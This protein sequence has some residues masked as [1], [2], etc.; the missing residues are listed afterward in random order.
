MTRAAAVVIGRNEGP[1]LLRCLQSV[2]GR[3]DPVVYVDSASTDGSVDVARQLGVEVVALDMSIRFSF[4]RARNAGAARVLE[5]APDV[6]LVQFVD[7][8]SEIV[9]SWLAQA[10]AVFDAAANVAAVHG[11][12]RERHPRGVLYDHLFELEF[13]PCTEADE[14]FGGMTLLRVAAYTASGRYREGM[15]TFEDHEL[16]FRLRRAGWQIRRLD[17]DMAIHEAGMAHWR[18]WWTRERRAGYGRAELLRVHGWMGDPGWRRAYASIWF[19]AALLP[20]TG[21]VTAPR[22]PAVAMLVCAGY[23]AFLYRIARRM[24]RRGFGTTDAALYAA[25]RVIG[26]FPQL[27]GVLAFL[28]HPPPAP[29]WGGLEGGAPPAPAWGAVRVTYLINQYPKIT[30]TFVRTEIAAVEG[31]GV[32]VDRVAIRRAEA[33][34]L[35]VADQREAPRTRVILDAGIGGLAAALVR[36]T[37]QRPRQFAGALR[38]ALR[39]ERRSERGMAI[40]LAYLAEACVL[41]RWTQERRTEHLHATFGANNAAVALLCRLLGGPPYSFTAHGPEEFAYAEVLSIAEKVAHAAFV[42]VVSEAGRAHLQQCC[43]PAV[44]ERIHLVRCG[45][46][47]RFNAVEP[48]PVPAARRIVWVGRLNAEKAPLLLV[49]AVARLSAAGEGC[50]LVMIGDGPLRAV[51][52]ARVRSLALSDRITLIGWASSDDVRRHI[53]CARALVLPSVAEGLPIVLMEAL[54]LRRPVICTMVGGVAELVESGACGWLVPPGSIDHLASA[55]G[56][57]LNAAPAELEEMGRNGAARVARQ[58]DPTIAAG[59]LAKLFAASASAARQH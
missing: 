46:D 20:V 36:T 29:G 55:I 9:A 44:W 37:L 6:A 25:G 3:F 45:V 14:V 40:H 15:L 26:K 7:A 58:H 49:E 54:A 2:V 21:V 22:W 5:L 48:T 23:V 13:N 34:L 31:A 59:T 33:A 38:M 4:G 43:P 52:E 19:W 30:H 18:A 35:D 1:R 39:M 53:L 57:V 50:D 16:S 47:A 42:A 11:R 17:A 41:L 32:H 51:V 24:R 8:D 10:A 12:V 56:K 27:Q 28:S